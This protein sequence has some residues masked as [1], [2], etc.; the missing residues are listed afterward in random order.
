MACW[1]N[2]RSSSICRNFYLRSGV[3]VI[4]V[5]AA[6]G[7]TSNC[8]DQ[9]ESQAN[10]EAGAMFTNWMLVNANFRDGGHTILSIYKDSILLQKKIFSYNN[11][12][13][14]TQVNRVEI[15]IDGKTQS[16]SKIE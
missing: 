16:Q 7:G 3:S 6:H 9:E 4:Q 5:D 11:P 10:Q 15:N 1:R 2:P 13:I 8:Q 14:P 12:E